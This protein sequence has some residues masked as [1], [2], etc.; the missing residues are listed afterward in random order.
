MEKFREFQA[1]WLSEHGNKAEIEAITMQLKR[2]SS[3]NNGLEPASAGSDNSQQ[4]QTL[5][6]P[7][8]ELSS[9]TIT[10]PNSEG[11]G[12]AS[13]VSTQVEVPSGSAENSKQSEASNH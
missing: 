12:S 8:K 7:V 13:K 1:R 3:L 2:R 4:N 9:V 11:E 6:S 10:T 5:S